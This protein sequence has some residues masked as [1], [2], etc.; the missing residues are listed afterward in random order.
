[1][2]WR[3]R[4]SLRSISEMTEFESPR[5]RHYT[6][7]HDVPDVKAFAGTA[8]A[9]PGWHGFAERRMA[10]AAAGLRGKL[11]GVDWRPTAR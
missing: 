2:R 6:I 9:L 1:M 11:P 8:I 3:S 4:P 5:V 7:L 10:I